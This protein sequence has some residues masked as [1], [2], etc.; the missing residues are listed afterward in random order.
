M[1]KFIKD[2]FFKEKKEKIVDENFA[3]QN[4]KIFKSILTYNNQALQI[5]SEL[6]RA[7]SE[8]IPISLNYIRSR[9]ISLVTTIYKMIENLNILSNNKYKDLYIYFEEIVKNIETHISFDEHPAK[10]EQIIFLEDIDIDLQEKVGSKVANLGELYKKLN[11][12]VPYG[13]AITKYAYQ[14]FMEQASLKDRIRILLTE[15]DPNDLESIFHQASKIKELILSTSLPSELE[16]N[17][18]T[19]FETMQQKLNKKDLKVSV[20]SSA[21]GEDLAHLSFAGQ[22]T[23]KLNVSKEEIIQAY[24]EVVASKYNPH[25]IIYRLKMGLKDEDVMM[26]VGVLEMIAGEVSGVVYSANPINLS[27]EI[28]IS[29]CYGLA[30]AIVEGIIENDVFKVKKDKE[31]FVIIEKKIGSK[32]RGYFLKERGIEKSKIS[33]SLQNQPSLSAQ[34]VIFLAQ[35]SK[36]IESY[37]HYPQDIEWT[38]SQN[39]LYILQSR[40]LSA[41]NTSFTEEELEKIKT[42]KLQVLL[43]G[44]EVAS[45][46]VAMGKVYKAQKD[47]DLW[48]FPP[49]AILVVKEASPKWALVLPQAAGLIAEFGSVNGHLANVARE[50]NLPALVGVKK[51]FSSL[52]SGQEIT[53]IAQLK[54][55]LAGINPEIAQKYQWKPPQVNLE[56]PVF[57]TLKK[58]NTFITPLNLLSPQKSNFKPSGCKTLHD[59]TRFI[60][61]K[62]VQE[63]FSTSQAKDF[64]GTLAKQLKTSVPM[65]WWVLNLGDGFKKPVKGKYVTLDNI[66]SIPMLAIWHGITAIPWEGPPVPDGKGL[67]SLIFQSTLNPDLEPLV[68]SS[69]S[70]KNYFMISKDFCHLQSRFGFHFTGIETLAGE[71]TKDNFI[72][73][74]FKG[75]ATDLERRKKRAIFIGEILKEYNFEVEIIEDKLDARLDRYEVKPIVKRLKILGYLIIHTRQLDIIMNNSKQVD[76]YRK[77]IKKDISLILKN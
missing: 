24:K 15:I 6:E 31:R 77:K 63:M 38:L 67:A 20:R 49:Q 61:E 4:Y 3:Y 16:Q 23:S 40:P 69:Y 70:Q 11:I 19:A 22:Y 48:T 30:K 27:D 52:E 56:G 55:I 2:L 33:P 47:A 73:F 14:L 32:T 18:L 25:A 45:P 58:I 65:Q 8:N 62:A 60:H 29:S 5:M 42:S 57:K 54:S 66:R 59:L 9:C 21:L 36:K 34:Q 51:A 71:R 10:G 43:E 28:I 76:Y 64:T 44:G 75:G 46:G 74:Q 39:Q 53:L 13:F 35:E 37:Y 72:R 68:A 17:I 1:L 50:F 41:S 7:L 26:C 12:K